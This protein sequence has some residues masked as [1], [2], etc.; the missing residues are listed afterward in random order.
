MSL[1]VK[2]LQ[3]ESCG[4]QHEASDKFDESA[5]TWSKQKHEN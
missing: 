3:H 5:I 4:E 2:I 1:K